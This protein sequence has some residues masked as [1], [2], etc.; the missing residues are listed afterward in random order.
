MNETRQHIILT[1]CELLE[2]QGYHATGLKEIV[3]TSG[4]PRGSLY[5]YFPGGKEQLT[6]EALQ[7]AGDQVLERIR[8][9]L[10]AEPDVIEAISGFILL[11]ARQVELS[12]YRAGGPITT[13]A[14]ETASTSEPLRQVCHAI[15]T[16]WQAAFAE[17]LRR[18][19]VDDARASSLAA[20]VISLLEGGILLARTAHSPQPLEQVAG[21]VRR[22]LAATL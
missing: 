11:V 18:A 19:Q 6:A 17:R 7:N 1:T 8:R 2:R 16:G 10:A 15:Y 20:L 9:V 13:V 4:S 12:G 22:L 14:L 3:E 21:E 5:H